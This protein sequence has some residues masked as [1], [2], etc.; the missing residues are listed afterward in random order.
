MLFMHIGSEHRIFDAVFSGQVSKGNEKQYYLIEGDEQRLVMSRMCQVF[1]ALDLHRKD[2]TGVFNLLLDWMRF[3]PQ[4]RQQKSIYQMM[5]KSGMDARAQQNIT[6][7]FRYYNNYIDLT[8][9]LF[10]DYSAA[11]TLVQET[12]LASSILES[13]GIRQLMRDMTE[14]LNNFA[15]IKTPDSH[16][17]D[18]LLIDKYSGLHPQWDW[19]SWR[20]GC[21]SMSSKQLLPFLYDLTHKL[22]NHIV[23]SDSTPMADGR[24]DKDTMRVNVSTPNEDHNWTARARRFDLPI[25]AGPSYTTHFM[26]SIAKAANATSAEMQAFAYVIFAYWN[27][28]YPSTATPVHRMFGVMTAAAE[29]DVDPIACLPESMYTQAWYFLSAHTP[30]SL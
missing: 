28:V 11:T 7:N 23:W 20:S 1:Q 25:W 14:K 17:R 24:I 10:G 27:R 21:R 22:K 4:D 15:E 16:D 8:L 13:K 19:P 18:S 6:A 9:A 2:F 12:A 26:L 3:T 29:F 30:A 5:E